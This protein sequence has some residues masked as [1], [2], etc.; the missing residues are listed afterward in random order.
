MGDLKAKPKKINPEVAQGDAFMKEGDYSSAAK[1]YENAALVMRG[2][3]FERSE[4]CMKASEA[5]A[6]LGNY[7]HAGWLVRDVGGYDEINAIRTFPGEAA[8]IKSGKAI[9]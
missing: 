4:A 2:K 3:S 6:K 1:A 8:F 5:Y 9:V 7:R